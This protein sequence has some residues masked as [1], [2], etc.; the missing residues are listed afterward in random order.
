MRTSVDTPERKSVC[1]SRAGEV[2]MALKDGRERER[3]REREE[4]GRRPSWIFTPAAELRESGQLQQ[5][6]LQ[7]KEEGKSF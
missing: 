6:S 3:R 4:Q 1:L 7:K 2:E 5:M